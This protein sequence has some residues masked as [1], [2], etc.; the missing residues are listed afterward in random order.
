MAKLIY[1]AIASLDGYIEDAGGSFDWA[2]PDAEVHTFANDLE[3]PVGTHLFGRRM[4]ETMV[5][6]ETAPTS[7][8]HEA[9]LHDSLRSGSGDKVVYSRRSDAG[10]CPDADRAGLRPG[11][12]AQL[13][14]TAERDISVGGAELGGEALPAGL[15]EEL[16]LFL[17]PVI[18]GGGK[19]ALPNDVRLALELLGER[20]FA[21]GTVYLHY[22]VV[23]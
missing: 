12:V 9:I 6:W 15:V 2:A 18:V 4:Y 23:A 20:R 1:S 17:V 5:Y 11:A 21:N 22:R 14:A 8:G 19:R 13:K 10:Q 16:Q 7:G 3:R